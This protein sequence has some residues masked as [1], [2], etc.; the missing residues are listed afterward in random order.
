MSQFPTG[1]ALQKPVQTIEPSDFER[2][3]RSGQLIGTRKRD[4]HR[5]HI[6]T[7][8]NDTQVFSRNGS[9]NHTEQLGHIA[10]AFAGAPPGLLVDVELHT[11]DEG[12]FSLQRAMNDN[13][14]S[15]RFSEFDLIDLNGQ[16]A[17]KGFE[18]RR[19]ALTDLMDTVGRDT[20]YWGGGTDYDLPVEASYD[21]VLARIDRDRIEGVVVWHRAGIHKLNRNGNTKRGQCWKIK[22]RTVEDVFV[23]RVNRTPDGSGIVTIEV[24]RPLNGGPAEPIGK[25]GSFTAGFDRSAALASSGRFMVQISHFGEDDNGNLVFPKAELLRPD[26]HADYGLAA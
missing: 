23:T 25:I 19:K 21:D 17:D 8:G 10:K 12:T 7:A 20:R 15:I 13:P 18:V 22:V 16:I 14:E 11:P 6:L 4:G 24:S 1:W 3:W 2:M 5:G 9:V 26:L